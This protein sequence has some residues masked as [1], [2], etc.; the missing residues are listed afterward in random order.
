ML[1]VSGFQ[2]I[3]SLMLAATQ[4]FSIAGGWFL[5]ALLSGL[6]AVCN[7]LGLSK[8]FW[9]A[10]INV[11]TWGFITTAGFLIL[12]SVMIAF[13]GSQQSAI[14]RCDLIV[15]LGCKVD[16]GVVNNTLK[17]RLE[18]ALDLSQR[19][20]EAHIVVSGGN[21]TANRPPESQIMFD[22]LISQGVNDSKIFQ[23]GYS[24]NTI[25]NI[26]NSKYFMDESKSPC[27]VSS[28][29]HIPRIRQICHQADVQAGF[30]GASAPIV[31]IPHQL[32]REAI[33]LLVT[34]WRIS[35]KTTKS[36]CGTI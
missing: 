2:L 22:Y 20:P 16:N 11:L 8:R 21:A 3:Y 10:L 28:F 6:L 35:I 25:E 15:V 34:P 33:A 23:E 5:M 9:S 32:L 14:E 29:Y 13:K 24:H 19:N 4:N 30:A 27:I 18:L 36:T 7:Q 1:G 17:A 31:L 26:M 12:I